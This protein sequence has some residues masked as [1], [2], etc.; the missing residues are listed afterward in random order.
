MHEPQAAFHVYKKA[1]SL[2]YAQ[3]ADIREMKNGLRTALAVSVA[4]RRP[5][6]S[7]TVLRDNDS[8][9]FGKKAFRRP[10]FSICADY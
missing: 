3:L 2:Q 8:I 6:L 10:F 5:I 7:R 4:S 9:N 1:S